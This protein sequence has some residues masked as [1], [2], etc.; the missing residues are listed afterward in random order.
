MV[1]STRVK[2]TDDIQLQFNTRLSYRMRAAMDNY[3][4]YMTRP[5]KHRPPETETWPT[6]I[7]AVVDDALTT[8]F[9]EHPTRVRKGPDPNKL[10]R[11]QTT[12]EEE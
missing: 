8:F 1:K 5:L 4:E 9:A 11:K 12:Q 6:T 3:M 7:V 2:L 10:V